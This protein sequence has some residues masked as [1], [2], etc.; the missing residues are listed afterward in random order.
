MQP[1]RAIIK[2]L[3]T[4]ERARNDY[5]QG[6]IDYICT[7]YCESEIERQ[8]IR[9]VLNKSIT[10]S[11]YVRQVAYIQNNL[12]LYK[13]DLINQNKRNRAEKRI[14]SQFSANTLFTSIARWFTK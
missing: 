8:V 2:Q 14:R 12:W 7:H 3:A 1:N 5:R 6:Y 13:P 11:S 4:S 10:G 9:K